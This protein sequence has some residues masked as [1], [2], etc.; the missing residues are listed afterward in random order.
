MTRVLAAWRLFLLWWCSFSFWLDIN[1]KIAVYCPESFLSNSLMLPRLRS[2][3]PSTMLLYI[4]V[5]L[6]A[7]LC[8]QYDM[9]IAYCIITFLLMFFPLNLNDKLVWK[10]TDLV[11]IT[12]K[13]SLDSKTEQSL[14]LNWYEFLVSSRLRFKAA[15][16][17]GRW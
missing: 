2:L 12:A 5:W 4:N 13:L 7:D 9:T 3:L 16:R 8:S 1:T 17:M 10:N 6:L 14:R 15:L 11:S